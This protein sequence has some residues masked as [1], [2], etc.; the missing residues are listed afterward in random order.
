MS[1]KRELES[2]RHK[3]TSTYKHADWIICNMF[4]S[5]WLQP[6]PKD[7]LDLKKNKRNQ[8]KKKTTHKTKQTQ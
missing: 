7:F 2:Q 1:Q 8:T 4:S 6:I 3:L 5:I